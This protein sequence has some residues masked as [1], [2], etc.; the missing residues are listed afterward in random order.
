MDVVKV[1]QVVLTMLMPTLAIAAV[2]NLPRGVRATRRLAA[3]RKVETTPQPSHPPIE[4]LAA[5]LRRLLQ[6]HETLRR[7]TGVAM[8]GRHLLALESAITDCAT[9]AATAL[10]LPA[11]DRPRHGGLATPELRR[12]LHSLANAGIVLPPAIGLLAA[13]GHS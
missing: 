1:G 5:D 4:Q 13:D 8:R 11:P 9:D 10:D 2:L 7:T 6:R 12:L 3:K